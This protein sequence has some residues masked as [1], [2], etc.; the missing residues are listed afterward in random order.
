MFQKLFGIMLVIAAFTLPTSA[1]DRA[2]VSEVLDQLHTHAGN[3]AWDQ[4]FALY[5]S[6]STFLGTDVSERW[7]KATFQAYAKQT[8]GWIYK[9]RERHID[10]TPDGN[11][12]WFDEVLDSLNY[13]TSRGTG[14][15]VRTDNGWKITQYHLVFPI[16]NDIAGSVTQ[17]IQAY[18]ARLK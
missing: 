5:T 6:D 8:N 9:M 15:L 12:A 13:G 18:E 7:D 16:P 3:A 1:N 4:Y 10:F 2:D 14:V 17:Q 11:T